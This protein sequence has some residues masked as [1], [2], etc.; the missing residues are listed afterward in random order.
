MIAHTQYTCIFI[1]CTA[2]NQCCHC[3]QLDQVVILTASGD[4]LNC[5]CPFLGSRCLIPR[6]TWLMFLACLQRK[7]LAIS[8][9]KRKPKKHANCRSHFYVILS[10][11]GF[12]YFCVSYD[13]LLK[14][15]NKEKFNLRQ[16][17]AHFE[18]RTSVWSPVSSPQSELD[19]R[20]ISFA[21]VLLW[22]P[23]GNG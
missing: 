2:R 15:R 21:D 3:R 10:L 20:F 11:K 1:F 12:C 22:S 19:L 6:A 14:S 23:R 5:H 4:F 9:Q 7:H 8:S 16:F 17:L 18:K 13:Q